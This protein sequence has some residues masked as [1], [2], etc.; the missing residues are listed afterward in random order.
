MHPQKTA[1]SWYQQERAEDL[2]RT[3]AILLKFWEVRNHKPP[4]PDIKTQADKFQAYLI[5]FLTGDSPESEHASIELT[6]R[7]LFE[8]VK[9]GTINF[10]DFCNTIQQYPLRLIY[11]IN[12]VL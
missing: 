12:H 8:N 5:Y 4:E 7:N 11:I 3:R 9:K 6:I 10:D 2:E 1:V